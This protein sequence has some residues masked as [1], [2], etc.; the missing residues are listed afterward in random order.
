[1]KMGSRAQVMLAFIVCHTFCSELKEH[2]HLS[3]VN[4]CEEL[5]PCHQLCNNTVGSFFC[6]CITG[7]KLSKDNRTCEGVLVA[8]VHFLC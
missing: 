5:Y 7:F 6:G 8:S 2:V 4:E 3:D 1:M